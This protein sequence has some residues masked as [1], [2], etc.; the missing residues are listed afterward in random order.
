[1]TATA[2]FVFSYVDHTVANIRESST[3]GVAGAAGG[4]AA[5]FVSGIRTGSIPK[6]MGMCAF[7]GAAIGTYDLAGG[8]LG[9]EKGRK[10]RD[11]REVERLDFFKKRVAE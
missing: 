7:L 2:G 4:C 8:Q 9:W 1:M 10:S 5:G 11:E 3:D 6:A